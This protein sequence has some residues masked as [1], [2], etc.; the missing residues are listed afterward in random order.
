MTVTI[1]LPDD[2][3]A[4]LRSRAAAERLSVEEYA[5]QALAHVVEHPADAGTW[6]ARNQRRLSLIR[7][8]FAGRLTADEDVELSELQELADRQLEQLDQQMLGDIA[9]LEAQ[10]TRAMDAKGT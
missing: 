5:A 7:K 3:V 10:A 2:L 8:R 1:T 9:D 4:R 6:D